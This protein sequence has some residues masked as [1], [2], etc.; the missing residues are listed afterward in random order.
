MASYVE[1]QLA[2]SYSIKKK[3]QESIQGETERC[4][5]ACI[6]DM[7]IVAWIVIFAQ[8]ANPLSLCQRRGLKQPVWSAFVLSYIEFN[9][10][11]P[12]LW[13][14]NGKFMYIYIYILQ[15]T[16]YLKIFQILL[17]CLSLAHH[18]DTA[19]FDCFVVIRLR[20]LGRELFH[21]VIICNVVNC[22]WF[23]SNLCQLFSCKDYCCSFCI[24]HRL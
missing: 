24:L 4:K 23:V 20:A 3:C 1:Y 7:C 19:S 22:M 5:L 21:T 15:S 17:E 6:L 8:S 10:H 18:V 11:P 14:K 9:L 16:R 12:N 2:Y 13:V